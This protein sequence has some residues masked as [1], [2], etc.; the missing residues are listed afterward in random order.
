[1]TATATR[2]GH[3]PGLFVSEDGRVECA[4]HAPFKG[5]DTW[6]FG[7]YVRANEAFE[8]YWNESMPDFAL[9]CENCGKSRKDAE[10]A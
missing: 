8:M 4:E 3:K 6:R 2:M 1:M 9:K 7:H 5:S 10:A